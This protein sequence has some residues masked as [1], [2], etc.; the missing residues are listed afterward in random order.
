MFKIKH[1]ENTYIDY[2]IPYPEMQQLLKVRKSMY[3][4]EIYPEY[5]NKE[6]LY[7]QINPFPLNTFYAT[8]VD[9]QI[10]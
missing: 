9:K 8:C 4:M 1:V 2:D 3:D 10:D 7:L 5:I 6:L